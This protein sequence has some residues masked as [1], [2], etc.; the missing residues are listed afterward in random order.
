MNLAANA[1]SR[2]SQFVAFREMAP[3]GHFLPF[4]VLCASSHP[5][6]DRYGERTIPVAFRVVQTN[7]PPLGE[8][9]SA[10]FG[11]D[12][13]SVGHLVSA[14]SGPRF[15]QGGEHLA[16]A[17]D[18]SPLKRLEAAPH[19]RRGP[20]LDQLIIGEHSRNRSVVQLEQSLVREILQPLGDFAQRRR[21]GVVD[22]RGLED[23]K[24]SFE[25][26]PSA[27]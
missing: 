5:L 19:L 11:L 4:L 8:S 27:S 2:Y 1:P 26:R 23:L 18:V 17:D 14:Q 6:L 16:R 15:I 20:V 7:E 13:N 3:G 12:S 22:P 9:P 21:N 25:S 10:I 24:G